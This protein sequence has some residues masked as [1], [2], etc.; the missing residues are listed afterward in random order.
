MDR[1]V[2]I[3]QTFNITAI[4]NIAD[5]ETNESILKRIKKHLLE[6]PD[7]ICMGGD[8]TFSLLPDMSPYIP[9]DE[10]KDSFECID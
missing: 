1:F 5:D 8:V 2:E 9:T 10:D 3:K 4:M 7:F 6:N